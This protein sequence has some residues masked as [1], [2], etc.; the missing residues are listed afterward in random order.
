MYFLLQNVVWIT[1]AAWIGAGAPRWLPWNSPSP[2][3]KVTQN[4][5]DDLGRL[6][7][8]IVIAH[9]R[10]AKN[11]VSKARNARPKPGT[12]ARPPLSPTGPSPSAAHIE[13][14]TSSSFQIYTLP[15]RGT[16]ADGH[17]DAARPR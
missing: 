10:R 16:G 1:R 6:K 17:G 8:T 12:R 5:D 2:L 7:T 13:V 11:P 9:P 3:H 15:T 4:L 14:H